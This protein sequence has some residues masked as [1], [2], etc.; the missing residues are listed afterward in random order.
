MPSLLSFLS[1]AVLATA[2]PIVDSS[3]LEY[4]SLEARQANLPL[5]KLPY[6]TWQASKY[7]VASDVCRA[8]RNYKPNSNA[9]TLRSTHS[10][11]SV[12]PLRQLATCDG[13]NQH[14]Q[15]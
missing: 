1:L 11:T 9:D 4:H 15:L 6:G 8:N 3:G 13:P 7:D 2:A 12:S 14:H 5:L 10:K